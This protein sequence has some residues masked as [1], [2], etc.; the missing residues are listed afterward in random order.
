MSAADIVAEAIAKAEAETPERLPVFYGTQT[1]LRTMQSLGVT[2]RR[3]DVV[4]AALAHVAERC[5]AETQR[6]DEARE[7]AI[8]R[9]VEVLAIVNRHGCC[10]D[11]RRAIE[12]LVRR[13]EEEDAGE[14]APRG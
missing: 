11:A 8:Q 2:Y 5:A 12:A 10:A 14:E 6:A 1:V 7:R 3:G 9:I 13:V 4:D